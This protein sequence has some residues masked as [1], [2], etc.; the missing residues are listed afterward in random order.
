LIAT[1]HAKRKKSCS[2]EKKTE[3]RE[4]VRCGRGWSRE[5]EGEEEGYGLPDVCVHIGTCN[6]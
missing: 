6:R 3:K 1:A 2:K 5:E 4:R